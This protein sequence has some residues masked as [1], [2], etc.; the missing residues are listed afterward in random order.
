M[1]IFKLSAPETVRL[2]SGHIL[3]RSESNFTHTHLDFQKIFR[4]E[5]PGPLLTGAGKEKGGDGKGLKGSYTS[6]G[7]AEGKDSGGAIGMGGKRRGR[8]SGRGDLAPRS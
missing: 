8:A 5:T 4:R 3:P 6:K 2:L 7:S 1:P